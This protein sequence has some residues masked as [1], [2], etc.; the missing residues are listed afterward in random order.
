MICEFTHPD[1]LI[2]NFINLWKKIDL[3][4]NELS[5]DNVLLS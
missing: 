1:L 5:V 2:S 4:L 3:N